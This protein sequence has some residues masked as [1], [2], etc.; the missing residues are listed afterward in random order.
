MPAEETRAAADNAG[1]IDT[2]VKALIAVVSGAIGWVWHTSSRQTRLESRLD[3]VEAEL[4][5]VGQGV[6]RILNHL[7]KSDLHDGG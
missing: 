4:K 6:G 5:H 7:T 2:I 3:A 1:L